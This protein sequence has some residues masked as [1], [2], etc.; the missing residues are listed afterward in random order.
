MIG[1]V[2][3]FLHDVIDVDVPVLVIHGDS[4]RIVPFEV[5]GQRVPE[6]AP[7]AT[8]ELIEGA[9][10]GLNITHAEQVN[11]LLLDFLRS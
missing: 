4:D 9:P 11:E 7:D 1:K 10:H 5:S 3:A 2:E 8:V 6:F